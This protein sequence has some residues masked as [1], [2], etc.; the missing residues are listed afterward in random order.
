MQDTQRTPNQIDRKKITPRYTLIKLL[1]TSKEKRLKSTRGGN[2]DLFYLQDNKDCNYHYNYHS[3]ETMQIK[4]QENNIFLMLKKTE[5]P[6]NSE[7][8]IQ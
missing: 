6:L 4:R 5:K 3:L 1:K 8:Y 2:S 7:F